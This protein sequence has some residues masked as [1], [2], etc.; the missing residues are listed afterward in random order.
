[1]SGLT[2]HQAGVIRFVQSIRDLITSVGIWALSIVDVYDVIPSTIMTYDFPGI[3]DLIGFDIDEIL[4]KLSQL[5]PSL[6]VGE[7]FMGYLADLAI[8]LEGVSYVVMLGVPLFYLAKVII[9]DI[10]L[11][12]LEAKDHRK[13]YVRLWSCF[14]RWIFH[15]EKKDE[16][17]PLREPTWREIQQH[18]LESNPPSDELPGEE[19]PDELD[20]IVP[21]KASRQL[22]WFLRHILPIVQNVV[23]TLV[24]FWE[25]GAG[26]WR[27]LLFVTWAINLNVASI[28][29]SAVAAYFY[30]L[31]T[32]DLS[33]LLYQLA[34]L[35][36]DLLVMLASAPAVFWVIPGYV[37]LTFIRETV[38]DRRL[39]GHEASNREFI[40]SLPLSSLITGW[41]ASG[42]TATVTDIG[43][44]YA[45]MLREKALDFMYTLNLQFREVPWRYVELTI[46][47]LFTF[48]N[49]VYVDEN[50]Q[51]RR[52]KGIFNLVG[53]RD[54][55]DE[56]R[57]EY[58]DKQLPEFCFGYN[59]DVQ[60]AFNDNGL[61][62]TDV[63]DA[64]CIYS[65]L[66]LIYY[67]DSSLIV[68]SY[69]VRDGLKRIDNGHFPLF[70][71][72]FFDRTS[73]DAGEAY[74]M[75]HIIDYDMFRMGKK[76]DHRNP[77]VGVFEFGTVL[78]SEKGKER[79]NAVENQHFKKDE[80]SANPK[81]DLFDL[82]LKM[83]R[84]AA[85]V[86]Y[87]TFAKFFSDEQRPESVGANERE[88]SQVIHMD[89]VH[90][91]GVFCP[92]FTLTAAAG[93]W[94]R[95]SFKNFYYQYR[96]LRSD[97][98]L[99]VY[100]L[101]HLVGGIC[102][103]VEKYRNLY[104]YKTMQLR[105]EDGTDGRKAYYTIT[106]QKLY[107]GRYSTDCLQ[108]VYVDKIRDCRRSLSDLETYESITATPDE[109]QKQNSYFVRDVFKR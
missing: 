6:F 98:T 23:D 70:D 77:N 35:L 12:P 16:T 66:Y 61:M 100:L 104:G 55:F 86:N 78:M 71:V 34:K 56:L 37:I 14:R 72:D 3:A 90:K 27:S 63:F 81:N 74:L 97:Q 9:E 13:W 46:E 28:A 54:Y 15:H 11:K 60:K 87:Y 30:I 45:A 49:A 24:E 80:P 62:V 21:E 82:E 41:M 44:S 105:L 5:F 73:Y 79:G 85:T 29:V 47:Y 91:E 76:F 88:V 92:F 108:G 43:L 17:D 2:L 38:G 102:G 95:S 64:M 32:F 26:F 94:I 50:N 42:K 25:F 18:K 103:Y 39:R 53:I 107:S 109:L 20:A 83:R 106:K 33:A 89:G 40:E 36:V 48:R 65:Q 101:N 59:P 58:N 99:M 8:K 7:H 1:M 75:S 96:N 52:F 69:A 84:H 93:D 67:I 4:R 10:Y 51:K 22:D 68:S 19:D 57:T 31:G